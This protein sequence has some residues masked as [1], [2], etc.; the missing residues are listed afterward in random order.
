M[1]ATHYS[2]KYTTLRSQCTMQPKKD[3]VD[4]V[5]EWLASRGV[6]PPQLVLRPVPELK[7]VSALA[8]LKPESVLMTL[9]DGVL[10][11]P[12]RSLALAHAFLVV[13]DEFRSSAS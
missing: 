5:R 12:S 9:G 1:L 10:S 3:P 2:D 11:C 7:V 4:R 13:E 6:C 8:K